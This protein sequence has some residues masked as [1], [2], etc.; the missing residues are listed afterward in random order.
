MDVLDWIEVL[1]EADTA[2]PVRVVCDL[3]R[4]VAAALDAALNRTAFGETEPL[5]LT[6]R[7]VKPSNLMVSRDGEVK[8]TD[9]GTGITTLGGRD[10]RVTASRAG[11]GRYLSPGRRHGKRGGPSSDV[12][13]LGL[14]GI[15]VLS[16]RWLQ[17]VRDDN[18]AHD[19]HLAEIVANLD[20][21]GMRSPQDDRT[22][23]S[24]LLRM[25]AF[26]PDARP[27]AAEVAQTMRTLSDRCPGA[28]LESFA[29][30]HVLPYLLPNA[31]DAG[32]N[33]FPE[34]T[35][36]EPA[37]MNALL[38]APEGA[39]ASLPP[40][41]PEEEDA[42][43]EDSVWVPASIVDDD[44]PP[45]RPPPAPNPP[46]PPR[47]SPSP[48]SSSPPSPPP[49]PATTITVPTEPSPVVEAIVPTPAAPTPAAPTPAAPPR[50]PPPDRAFSL[51]AGAA[52]GAV[53][54][55]AVAGLSLGF[56]V[57]LLVGG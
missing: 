19:R 56:A 8:L 45:P 53:A 39:E 10:G 47:P 30:G 24:L 55:A 2:V 29:H 20:D 6:H 35:V 18:P 43:D 15:E 12:Y 51:V 42:D 44:D 57:G 22:L 27:P 36:V 16:G 34:A 17:R 26:D 1:R 25:V 11:L 28:S 52:L 21:F 32:P 7:D 38:D 9:F 4:G 14:I 13:A 5:G 48:R 23:R 54:L 31:L 40:Q 50:S 46:P 41:G 37:A 3:I 33:V 49:S